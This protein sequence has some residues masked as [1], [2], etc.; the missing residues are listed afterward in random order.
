MDVDSNDGANGKSHPCVAAVFD[1]ESV[2]AR[3]GG[4]TAIFV[5][6]AEIFLETS[7]E[8][9]N[10]MREAVGD[11]E[12]VRL[13]RLAHT[14]KGSARALAADQLFR[15]ASQLEK[16]GRESKLNEAVPILQE[17]EI[18]FDCLVA[19]LHEKLHSI[20]HTSRT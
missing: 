15:L 10:E 2:I 6:L 9:L 4:S 16:M 12:P 3:F 13:E 7:H 18:A 14:F 1:Y 5:E 19:A 17:L 20:S 8:L 11:S